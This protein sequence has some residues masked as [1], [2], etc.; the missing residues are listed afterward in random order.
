VAGIFTSAREPAAW[1]NRFDPNR[2]AQACLNH[3][4]AQLR[5]CAVNA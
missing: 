5:A 3:D 4:R 1:I 2:P